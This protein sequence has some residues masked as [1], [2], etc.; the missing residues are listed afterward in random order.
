VRRLAAALLLLAALGCRGTV[1]EIDVSDPG[2]KARIEAQMRGRSDL[3]LRYVTVDVV[4]GAVT[5]SGIVPNMTQIR[6]IN[7]L[8]KRT[9]GVEAALINLVVNE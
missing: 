6:A 3:D 1:Q 8:V 9:K 4:D 2:I 7:R 5:V